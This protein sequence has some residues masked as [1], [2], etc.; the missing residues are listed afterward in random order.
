MSAKILE[1]KITFI[2]HDKGY[3]MIEYTDGS[4]KKVAKGKIDMATQKIWKENNKIKKTHHFS[5]GDVLQ[6]NLETSSNGGRLVASFL[7]FKFNNALNNLLHKATI[8]N[9]FL[10]YLKQVDKNFFVKEIDSYL[11]FPISLSPWQLLPAEK[12][13]N[14]PVSFFLNNIQKKD[15]ITASLSNNKYLPEFLEA[16]KLFKAQQIIQSTVYK[17]SPHAYYVYVVGKVITAKIDRALYSDKKIELGSVLPI[18]ISFLNKQKIAV[19]PAP[20]N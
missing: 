19:A 15:H 3:A 13:L 9:K 10:G 1:G 16:T 20:E 2:N 11:F 12:D 4:K 14:E 5:V 7:Q 18:T 8:E 6:F 17:I